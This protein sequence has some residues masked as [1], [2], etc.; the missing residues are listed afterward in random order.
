MSTERFSRSGAAFRTRRAVLQVMA[1]A[2]GSLLV[3]IAA[4]PGPVPAALAQDTIYGNGGMSGQGQGPEPGMGHGGGGSI[5]VGSA[6]TGMAPMGAASVR[7]VSTHAGGFVP[8]NLTVDLG[9]VVE[10]VNSTSVE[11]TATGSGF[12]TGIIPP[13]DTA[14]VVMDTPG[15]FPY[16][17]RIHPVMT[18]QI[19]VR[20]ANGDM[21]SPMNWSAPAMQSMA[22]VSIANFAF[23]PAT[24]FTPAGGTVTWRNDDATAHTVTADGGQFDSGILNPG[25]SFSWT[26]ADAGSVSY[27]CQLHLSMQ[28]SVVVGG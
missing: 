19:T 9:Q 4:R 16:A 5:Q 14:T 25:A 6:P 3:A 27:H 21:P 2:G 18:G 26:F 23:N 17:C 12:D 13:G 22:A 24:I 7:I 8:G 20:D 11:H 15:V 10:F 28:G 1:T